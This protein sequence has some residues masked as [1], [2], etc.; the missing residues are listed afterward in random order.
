MNNRLII[1]FSSPD[2]IE[3]MYQDLLGE[4]HYGTELAQ[5][6]VYIQTNTEVILLV[7]ICDVAIH[8]IVFPQKVKRRYLKPA[9]SYQLEDRLAE[10]MTD[11][12]MVI[13]EQ[14]EA[15]IKAAVVE[16]QLM[17]RWLDKLVRSD[18]Q[19]TAIIPLASAITTTPQSCRI[20]CVDD[21]ISIQFPN[22][23]VNG[24]SVNCALLLQSCQADLSL[25]EN[26]IIDNFTDCDL[27]KTLPPL[28]C[29][30]ENNT[31]DRSLLLP[32]LYAILK[33]SA[34]LL[35]QGYQQNSPRKAYSNKLLSGA[36]TVFFATLVLVLVNSII[37]NHKLNSDLQGTED[38]ITKIYHKHFPRATHVVA[39]RERFLAELQSLKRGQVDEGLL[40]ILTDVDSAALQFPAVTV[41]AIFYNHETLSLELITDGF[42]TLTAYREWLAMKKYQV[43]THNAQSQHNQVSAQIIISRPS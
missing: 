39:P 38:E 25:C 40:S 2:A 17:Q 42:D 5:S 22:K 34:N 1:Y 30:V 19:P 7:P 31:H 6:R 8:T 26:L 9:V 24:D 43:M 16:H 27:L 20:L 4:K 11:C 14:K 23:V 29:S 36:G 15:I 13:I 37:I 32:Y 10:P 3:W 12:H 18:I 33:P 28:P 41:N 35:Q 21:Q